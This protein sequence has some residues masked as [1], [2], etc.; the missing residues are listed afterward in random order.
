MTTIMVRW[1]N[2]RAQTFFRVS[3][4]GGAAKAI[5]M[6]SIFSGTACRSFPINSS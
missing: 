6:V 1:R 5:I 3:L 4:A 2:D